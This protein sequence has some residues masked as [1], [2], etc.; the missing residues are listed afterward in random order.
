MLEKY[1]FEVFVRY[2]SYKILSE[3]VCRKPFTMDL[4]S[5]INCIPL[6]SNY[7]TQK[8]DCYLSLVRFFL[9]L[10]HIMK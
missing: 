7:F 4:H 6:S 10:Q 2:S 9:F 5:L 1:F 8:C 3:I